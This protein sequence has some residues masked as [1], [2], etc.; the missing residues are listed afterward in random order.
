MHFSHSFPLFYR[1]SLIGQVWIH[2]QGIKPL[3]VLFYSMW[4]ESSRSHI[5]KCVYIYVFMCV[6]MCVWGPRQLR[7]LDCL[8]LCPILALLFLPW[9][10]YLRVGAIYYHNIESCPF[11]CSVMKNES[12]FCE[13]PA[14][15]SARATFQPLHTGTRTVCL[16][17]G[18]TNLL[19]LDLH[20]FLRE[21]KI[22]STGRLVKPS[23]FV[24]LMI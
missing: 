6:H 4:K 18:R 10:R 19:Q 17:R 3:T 7:Y 21:W 24:M 20:S 22:T 15:G 14:R 11:L 5:S 1:I 16:L 12:F 23:S 8:A 13:A 2:I 9:V